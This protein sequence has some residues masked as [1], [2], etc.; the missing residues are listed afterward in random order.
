MVNKTFFYSWTNEPITGIQ[1]SANGVSKTKM[2][3]NNI[4]GI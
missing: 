4:N 1:L 2:A 3:F